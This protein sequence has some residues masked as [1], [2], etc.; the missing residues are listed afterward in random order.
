MYKIE[1]AEI[2]EL[3][4]T[5]IDSPSTESTR[6]ETHHHLSQCGVRLHLNWVDTE[7]TN[8]Y[9]QYEDVIIPRWLSRR[10]VSPSDDS[11]DGDRDSVSTESP[12]NIKN[13]N[14]SANAGTKSKTLK[15]PISLSI[16]VWSVQK[17]QLKNLTQVYN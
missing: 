1:F 7:G 3:F 12:T 5:L 8:I 14:K 11:V 6:S 4:V 10:G 17:S 13:L 16:Y 15:S 2:L 9:V